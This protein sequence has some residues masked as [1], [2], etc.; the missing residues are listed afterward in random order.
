M[1]TARRLKHC[2]RRMEGWQH[3]SF[4]SRSSTI[5]RSFIGST[6]EILRCIW[7]RPVIGSRL[8]DFY[9]WPVPTRTR[10][11]I[12]AEAALCTTQRTDSSAVPRGMPKSRWRPSAASSIKAPTFI[13]RTRTVPLLC[14]ALSGRDALPQCDVFSEQ[15]VTRPRE[16]NPDPP[17]FIS[18]CKTPVVGERVQH[19]Q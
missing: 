12:T 10:Q 7:P 1:T 17:R 16:T 13:H 2:S 19:R 9:F 3:A 8:F 6:R 4:V 14:I 15:A 18:P 11:R 5:Q